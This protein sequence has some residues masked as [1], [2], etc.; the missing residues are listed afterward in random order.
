MTATATF[1]APKAPRRRP[2][3]ANRGASVVVGFV[4]LL[5][6]GVE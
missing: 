4:A 5:L 6:I 1:I 2:A 3:G